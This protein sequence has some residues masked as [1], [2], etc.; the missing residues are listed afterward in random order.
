MKRSG[1]LMNKKCYLSAI[2]LIF[3]MLTIIKVDVS[4]AAI[5]KTEGN[6]TWSLNDKGVLTISKAATPNSKEITF[7]EYSDRISSVVIKNGV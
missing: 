4:A 3:M 7:N 5:T 1:E 6:I 2:V